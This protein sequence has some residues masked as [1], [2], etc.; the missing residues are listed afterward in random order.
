M[1]DFDTASLSDASPPR[2]LLPAPDHETK[3][4]A[5]DPREARRAGRWLVGVG[6]LLLLTG[7]LAF[8]MWRHFQQ[9]REV[10]ATAKQQ[11]AFVPSVRT[12]VVERKDGR[13]H[14]T[15]P[16]TTLAFEQADIYARASGYVLKRN[17]D[18]GDRVKAGQLLAEITA[19]EVDYQVAQLRSSL[20]QAEAT[21][22]Q[23]EANRSLAQV[24]WGRDAILVNKGWVTQQQGDTDRYSYQAQQQ[25]TEAATKNAAA[26][27]AQLNTTNQQKLYQQVLAPFDGVVTQRNIDVGSLITANAATGT[28]MFTVVQS[29]VIRVWVYVPQDSAFGVAPGVEAVIRVPA[30]PDLTFRGKVTRIADALQPGTRTLLAEVDI[31]NPDGKLQPGLY[32]TVELKI[33]RQSP[34]LIVPASAIVFNRNGMQV[35]V[36]EDGVAHLRKIAIT[37]DYGTE[38]E[39]NEGVKEGDRVVLQP[40]VNL[41]DGDKVHVLAPPPTP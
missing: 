40:P 28:A 22:R 18:I 7:A 10:V 26:M 1:N 9:H 27:Q 8:G 24:T 36:V 25:A 20:Q 38:V 21:I 37:T 29:D 39:V 2:A 33:P 11:A 15:L 16:G 13:M 17:V 4:P 41:S 3:G 23:N 6:A 35:A 19:P 31:P 5:P 34:A 32:C 30:M 14:V 12:A